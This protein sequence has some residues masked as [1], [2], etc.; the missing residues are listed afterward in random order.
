M[1]PYKYESRSS[2]DKPYIVVYMDSVPFFFPPY[3]VSYVPT[4][5][6]HPYN[7]S[8]VS[9]GLGLSCLVGTRPVGRRVRDTYPC[10]PQTTET[11]NKINR[12][13]KKSLYLP[14]VTD[15]NVHET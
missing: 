3:R 7:G 12:R 5:C 13:K 9:S 6:Y 11:E 14:D 1:A 15:P 8:G 2:S 10:V 4:Q